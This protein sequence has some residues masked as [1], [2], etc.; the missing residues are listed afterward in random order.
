MSGEVWGRRFWYAGIA[1]A[2]GI[3]L[4][5]AASRSKRIQHTREGRSLEWVDVRVKIKQKDGATHN[6][7]GSTS[8]VV[9][10]GTITGIIGPSGS[11]KTTL[12][13]V[14]A[15]RLRYDRKLEASGK[16]KVDGVALEPGQRIASGYVMQEDVLFSHLTVKETLLNAF[17]LHSACQS[18][19]PTQYVDH[20]LKLMNINGI[21]NSIVG[22][23]QERGI[24]GGEKKRLAIACELISKPQVLFLDEPTSGL[25]SF[26]AAMVMKALRGLADSGCTV[27]LAIHQPR[28][29]VYELLDK[30]VILGSGGRSIFVG[31]RGTASS[32]FEGRGYPIP[33]SCNPPDYILD[34]V[35]L[36][37]TSDSARNE[38]LKRIEQ[39]RTQISDPCVNSCRS[40]LAAVG[41]DPLAPDSWGKRWLWGLHTFKVL[42]GRNCTQ[43]VRDRRTIRVRFISTAGASA[44]FAML[45][46]RLGQDLSQASV[47]SRQG[48]L[49]VLINYTAMTSLVKTINAFGKERPI[50]EREL[51]SGLYEVGP[52]LLAKLVTESSAAAFFPLVMGGIVYPTTGLQPIPTKFGRFTILLVLQS[53]VSS[54]LGLSFGA[55]L[56]LEAALEGGKTTMMMSVIFGGFYFSDKT[57]PVRLRWLSETSLIKKGFEAMVANEM[58]G[59]KFHGKPFMNGEAVIEHLGVSPNAVSIAFERQAF[60]I[61]MICIST[62]CALVWGQPQY[63]DLV[64][65]PTHAKDETPATL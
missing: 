23:V 64:E 10:A 63:A 62:Y 29:Q 2:G 34:L 19:S 46:W 42:F 44:T 28:G 47:I 15:G 11:G 13:N 4:Y 39:L 52:Y 54:M 61:L 48:L 27:V 45:Y 1:S 9:E 14:L 16:L 24:S 26:Q 25:D 21:Q 49:Q 40:P 6:V 41:D 38:S 56:P 55:A 65:K 57:L 7:V 36:D 18:E 5:L 51:S 33:A 59:L 22:N 12:L 31:P 20:I 60:L 32:Y 58:R 50:V 17:S 35:S 3:A 43:L 30:L 37:T 8:G 53:L